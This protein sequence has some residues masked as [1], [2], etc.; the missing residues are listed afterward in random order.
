MDDES[1]EEK[2][3][4]A[5]RILADLIRCGVDR[6]TWSELDVGEYGLWW[7]LPLSPLGDYLHAL[8]LV[9]YRNELDWSFEHTPEERVVS[10]V[11][12]LIE[13]AGLDAAVTTKPQTAMVDGADQG[14]QAVHKIV[15]EIALAGK[16][17]MFRPAT[18][19]GELEVDGIVD[20]LNCLAG[21]VVLGCGRQM[22]GPWH[23]YRSNDALAA[24]M[25]TLHQHAAESMVEHSREVIAAYQPHGFF[26]DLLHLDE[27]VAAVE[28]S[29]R[30]IGFRDVRLLSFKGRALAELSLLAT[31]QNRMWWISDS[32]HSSDPASAAIDM[33]EFWADCSNGAFVVLDAI[34]HGSPYSPDGFTLHA[35]VNGLP[36]SV[37]LDWGDWMPIGPVQDV[38]NAVIAPNHEVLA[39]TTGNQDGFATVAS[40]E[41]R[42]LLHSRG[43]PMESTFD[44]DNVGRW[45]R[46]S[47]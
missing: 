36:V 19:R 6:S 44:R 37:D 5:E 39:I 15:L 16:I 32:E 23:V 20:A 24:Y 38:V 4:A 1:A 10:Q 22:P 40:P 9:G 7:S 33:L 17:V 11:E 26:T 47:G 3:R 27:T 46:P 28:L 21:R 31:D 41:L 8:W 35:T 12:R 43:V 30:L 18:W 45:T 2:G 29:K 25:E 14:S 42:D 34:V 13:L